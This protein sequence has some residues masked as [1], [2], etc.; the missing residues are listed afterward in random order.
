[1]GGEIYHDLV[2]IRVEGDSITTDSWVAG[3]GMSYA[4]DAWIFGAQYSHR[5]DEF[6]L[7]S[8]EGTDLDLSQ[9]RVVA[10]AT[11]L[12]GPGMNFDASVGYTWLDADPDDSE[13]LGDEGFDD[14]QALEFGVGATLTF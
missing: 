9:D 8:D 5:E 7:S 13:L 12:F 1:M 10:T 6:S 11:Y 3:V 2:D 4:Y 14:Y